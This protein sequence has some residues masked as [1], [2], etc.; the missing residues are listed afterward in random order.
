MKTTKALLKILFYSILL[1]LS[2]SNIFVITVSKFPNY[3]ML[4]AYSLRNNLI[5]TKIITL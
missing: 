3:Y 2:N 1:R 4:K 5:K